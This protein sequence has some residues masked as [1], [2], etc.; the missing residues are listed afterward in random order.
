VIYYHKLSLHVSGIYMLTSRSTGC[1]LLH[2]VPS[3][4]RESK[5]LVV[6]PVLFSVSRI[7]WCRLCHRVYWIEVLHDAYHSHWSGWNCGC[8]AG[9]WR[10]L[11][12]VLDIGCRLSIVVYAFERLG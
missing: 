4:V 8:E 3:T 5:V 1:N 6:S 11:V 10:R 2:V 9:V 12:C 7:Y